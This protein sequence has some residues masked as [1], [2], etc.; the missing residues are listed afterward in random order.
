MKKNLIF[1]AWYYFRTGW[2]TYFAFIMA[3]INTLVVTYYLAI[4]NV[5]IL[6]DF[7]PSFTH[8]VLFISIIGVPILVLTGYIHFKKSA[9][10]K[11]E[12]DINIET[13]PHMRRILLNTETII[14]SELKLSKLILKMINNETLSSEESSEIKKLFSELDVY[15][16]NKSFNEN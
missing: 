8:Y 1:R 13:N 16:K 4:E 6:K 14:E 11:S 10:Y 15:L 9:A 7:F 2:G 5:P 3:A 12:A